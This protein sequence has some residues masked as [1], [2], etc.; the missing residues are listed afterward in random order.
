LETWNRALPA[1]S[2]VRATVPADQLLPEF[3]VVPL[4]AA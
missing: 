2:S 1:S 3:R 4:N